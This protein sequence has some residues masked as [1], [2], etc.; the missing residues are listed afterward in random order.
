MPAGSPARWRVRLGK[1][2]DFDLPVTGK[3]VRGPGDPVRVGDIARSW[4][5]LHVGPV[6]AGKPLWAAQALTYDVIDPGRREV[7][8]TI[9]TRADRGPGRPG[10]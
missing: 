2:V 4:T 5:A 1:R 8:V 9:P 6:P 3:V 10:R 7:V